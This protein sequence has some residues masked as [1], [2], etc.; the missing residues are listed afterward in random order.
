MKQILETKDYTLFKRIQGNRDIN[1]NHLDKLS[2]SIMENNMMQ[3]NPILVNEQYEIIDGQHRFEICKLNNFPIFYTV[4]EEA[5]L[6]DVLLLNSNNK[7]WMLK[8][9]LKTYV[10][11]N[12]QHYKA[13]EAFMEKYGLGITLSVCLLSGSSIPQGG[14]AMI[15]QFKS[16]N[17][18]VSQFENA[19]KMVNSVNKFTDYA[20][21][22]VL[23]DRAFFEAIR[24]IL[25][26]VEVRE[27]IASFEKSKDHISPQFS[28]TD[29]LRII[30]GVY[31]KNRRQEDYERFF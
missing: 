7:P 21:A 11:L 24:I 16:G 15:K 12:N 20:D 8:D 28:T 1:K 30:E 19:V 27:V 4:V 31:N 5:N 17:F 25:S 29:Y 22:R 13:L 2:A 6:R 23:K 18:N 26:Y 9:Y 10:S 14:S 3:V